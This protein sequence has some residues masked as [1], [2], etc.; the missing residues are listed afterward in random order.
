MR[1]MNFATGALYGDRVH[2][3]IEAWAA[4]HPSEVAARLA[5]LRVPWCVAAGWAV[6]LFLG[7]QTREHG[8]LEIAVPAAEAG[9]VLARFAE[10]DFYMPVGEGR[11]APLDLAGDSHQSWGYEVSAGRWR[12]DVFRE[13]HDGGTWICRRDERVRRP[14]GDIIARTPDGIPYLSPEIVLLFKAK[15]PRAKDRADFARVLPHLT[16]AQRTWFV[17][18]LAAVH[19]GH[20]WLDAA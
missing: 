2:P 4:W 15:A 8:D 6:D 20:E 9:A 13:P 10:L 17:T 12:I 3:D 14:Y 7:E 11:L 18:T 5:D 1:W 19:P 16:A